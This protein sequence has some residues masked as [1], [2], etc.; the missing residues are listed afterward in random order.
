MTFFFGVGLGI[1]NGDK[2]RRKEHMVV[3]IAI[4]IWGGITGTQIASF[5]WRFDPRSGFSGDLILD[6][7][8]TTGGGIVVLVLFMCCGTMPW[9]CRQVISSLEIFAVGFDQLSI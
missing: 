5:F 1:S 8:I 4:G 7:G 2:L 9:N 6:P 3:A